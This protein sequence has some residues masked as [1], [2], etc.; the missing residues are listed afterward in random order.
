MAVEH[1]VPAAAEL[2]SQRPRQPHEQRALAVLS[3]HQ[4]ARFT[5]RRAKPEADAPVLRLV[6]EQPRREADRGHPVGHRVVDAPDQPG[7]APCQGHEVKP[8]QRPG[9]IEALGEDP[10]GGV[11]EG[12]VVERLGDL[13]LGDV[14]VEIDLRRFDPDG[15]AAARD[16]DPA[17]ERLQARQTLGDPPAQALD[18]NA[19]RPGSGRLEHEQLAGVALDR[20]RLQM[21]DLGVVEAERLG[22]EGR[23]RHP[24][25]AVA[26]SR[27]VICF[28]H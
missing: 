28:S 5:E 26:R 24:I 19:S 10:A 3:G 11:A 13:E 15:R 25:M 2:A 8:P 7:A 12:I 18:I 4:A 20:I 22:F 21:K 23:H 16:L 17:A 9:V 6:P 1:G 27:S 14:P